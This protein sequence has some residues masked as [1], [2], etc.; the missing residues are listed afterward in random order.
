MNPYMHQNLFQ[1]L[2]EAEINFRLRIPFAE[3][4][5]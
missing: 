2:E 1:S 5:I 4:I 3:G